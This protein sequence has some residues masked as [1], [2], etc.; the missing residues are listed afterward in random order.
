MKSK[1]IRRLS[2]YLKDDE[3]KNLLGKCKGR[4]DQIIIELILLTGY[5]MLQIFTAL[6]TLVTNV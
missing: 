3:V 6:N 4:R 5:K 2:K 1:T